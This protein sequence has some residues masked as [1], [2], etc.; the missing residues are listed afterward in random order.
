MQL[1]F[2]ITA[3][4]NGQKELQKNCKTINCKRNFAI[5]RNGILHSELKILVKYNL[6]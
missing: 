6:I 5:Y 4:F 3:E 2:S 1:N